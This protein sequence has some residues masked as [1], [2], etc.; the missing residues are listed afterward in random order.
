MLSG[1]SEFYFECYKE[2]RHHFP[3]S[4]PHTLKGLADRMFNSMTH[5]PRRIMHKSEFRSRCGDLITALQTTRK[6]SGLEPG[7]RPV[8][9]NDGESETEK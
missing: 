3:G 2:T 9:A 4:T 5:K 8:N 1:E 6:M 7:E